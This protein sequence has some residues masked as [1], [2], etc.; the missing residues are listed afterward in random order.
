MTLLPGHQP[1]LTR[2]SSSRQARKEPIGSKSKSER[3]R[4]VHI[5]NDV[6]IGGA[7]MML[8]KLLSQVDRDRFE[9]IVVALRNRGELHRRIEAL[10]V[11]VYNVAMRRR[12]RDS[13]RNESRRLTLPTRTEASA[14][15]AQQC[16][17]R[18]LQ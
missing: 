8:Y 16:H 10:D 13:A 15:T 14:G 11:P 4:L 18:A 7:E 3:I 17:N 1:R 5:I 2:A 12:A 9:P 6:S